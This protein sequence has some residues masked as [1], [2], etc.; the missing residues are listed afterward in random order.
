MRLFFYCRLLV[1]VFFFCIIKWENGV[2]INTLRHVF[3]NYSVSHNPM[4]VTS[5]SRDRRWLTGTLVSSM[6]TW[7]EF[8][9]FLQSF[10]G[11][12]SSSVKDARLVSTLYLL[13]RLI[14]YGGSFYLHSQESFRFLTCIIKKMEISPEIKSNSF[15][16]DASRLYKDSCPEL[17]RFYM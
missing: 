5:E 12:F 9:H 16:L 6:Q 13:S 2:E 14:I 4:Q 3:P 8:I 15:L 10:R 7:W 17:S 1:F 11:S